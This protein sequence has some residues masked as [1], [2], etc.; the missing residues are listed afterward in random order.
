MGSK[1]GE[2]KYICSM[3]MMSVRFS[4]GDGMKTGIREERRG[5][6]VSG[7]SGSDKS[8]GLVSTGDRPSKVLDLH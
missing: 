5:C 2:F 1:R 6:D 8:L 3:H 7:T 4:S